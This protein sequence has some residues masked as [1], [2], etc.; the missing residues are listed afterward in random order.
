MQAPALQQ[1]ALPPPLP[2][3]QRSPRAGQHCCL[4]SPRHHYEHAGPQAHCLTT[5]DGRPAVDW[6]GRVESMEE[7]L[8]SLVEL[9][10]QRPG[11]PKLRVP[12]RG[13]L[14]H[15]NINSGSCQQSEPGGSSSSGAGIGAALGSWL[16]RRQLAVAAPQPAGQ[17]PL[18][19]A[20][21]PAPSPSPAAQ[22]DGTASHIKLP[23]EEW[24]PRK[25]TLNL[26]DKDAM[27]RGR[28]RHCYDAL[29]QFYAE[30]LRLLHGQ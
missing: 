2:S 17:A 22:G 20:A 8:T 4:P 23:P 6:V 26:C 12:R 29:S 30:D 19:S 16:R 28:Y 10:N 9:L 27:F 15:V 5:D 7:D 11:V 21:S 3:H 13:D 14:G 18:S 24:E 25:G 1:A